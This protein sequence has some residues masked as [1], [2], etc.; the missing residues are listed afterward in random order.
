MVEL[1]YVFARDGRYR[2]TAET[3][4]NNTVE[5][6]FVVSQAGRAIPAFGVVGKV[7]VRQVGHERRRPIQDPLRK[8]I[9][10]VANAAAEID[11]AIAGFLH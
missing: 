11:R 7:A 6:L 2:Q 8:G 4:Q 1:L 3:R 5:H 9:M 10:A